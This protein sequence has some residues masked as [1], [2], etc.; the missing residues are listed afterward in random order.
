MSKTKSPFD[1]F[2]NDFLIDYICWFLE[3][4]IHANSKPRLAE[5]P[6]WSCHRILFAKLHLQIGIY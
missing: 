3:T 2:Q 5:R 1:K 4:I 6:V